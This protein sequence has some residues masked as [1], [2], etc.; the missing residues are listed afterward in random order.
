MS[1]MAARR[2]EASDETNAKIDNAIRNL[3]EQAFNR[4]CDISRS[5]ATAQQESAQRL[6]DK[7]TFV[8][9]DLAPVRAAVIECRDHGAKTTFSAGPDTP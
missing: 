6:L 2:S 3:I 7:E 9:D 8:E 1:E 5:R 4:A